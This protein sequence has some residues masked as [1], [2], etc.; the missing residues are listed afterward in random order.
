M[1]EYYCPTCDVSE[2]SIAIIPKNKCEKCG[3]IK[4][5]NEWESDAPNLESA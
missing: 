1:I 4:E 5:A 3:L 2:I